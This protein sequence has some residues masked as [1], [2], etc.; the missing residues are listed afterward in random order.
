MSDSTRNPVLNPEPRQHITGEPGS[1]DHLVQKYT[2]T[3]VQL[4]NRNSGVCLETLRHDVT[5]IGMHYLLTHFDVPYVEKADDWKLTFERLDGTTAD[6]DLERLKDFEQIEQRVTLE[7]AGNGRVYME[8]RWA[9]MPWSSEAVGTAVWGGVRL[10]DVLTSLTNSTQDS[11]HLNAG[12]EPLEWVFSGADQGVD[13]GH[14]HHF[15]RSL[16]HTMA[17]NSDVMLAWQINGQSLPPQHGFPLRLIVPG[18]YGMASVK[19]LKHIK[20]ID[21]PFEGYQ[22]TGTYQYRQT[23]DDPGKPVTAI[24][25]R[26][27]MIPPGIPDWYTRQ[28]VLNGGEVTLRGRAWSG[29]GTSVSK[30]EVSVDGEWHKAKLESSTDKYAW[31]SWQFLWQSTPGEHVLQCRATDANGVVQ[32]LDAPWDKGGFGNNAV[33]SVKVWVE[34]EPE[35]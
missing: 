2:L 31:Q 22:Q 4:A 12:K 16:S 17:M 24:R 14:V 8:P 21:H 29:D 20:A 10:S 34:Q 7:C 1:P 23:L 6:F 25:V 5:P 3:E 19:W 18:W 27:L 15:E 26:S 32:P 28:R 9:S 30:V 13:N 33:H 11:A 35:L